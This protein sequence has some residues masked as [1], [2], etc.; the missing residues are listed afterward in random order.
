MQ[1]KFQPLNILQ[2]ASGFPGWGGTELHILN[3]SEQLTIRGHHVTVACRPGGWVSKKAMEMGLHTLD[4]TVIRQHDWSDYRK[5]KD[6][7]KSGKVDVVH[8]HW[9]TDAF[10]PAFAARVAG[11]PVRLMTRHSPYPF[12]TA[13]GRWLYTRVLYNR[14]LAI[15]GSV[16]Q[17]LINCG[18]P[19]DKIT[20]IHHGTNVGAFEN[21]TKDRESSRAEL[22]LT[23]DQVAVGI[24]GRIADEKGHRYLFD[25]LKKLPNAHNLRIVVVG[26]GP[27]ADEQREYVAANQL[28][29]RVIFSPFRADVNNVI[30]ALDIVTVPLTWEEPC[31]AVIQQAMALAKPV[32]GTKVGGTP[33]MI[34][35]GQTGVLVTPSDASS[36]ASAIETLL[37]D[38]ALR[39]KQGDAGAERVRALFTLDRMT[40]RIEELYRQELVRAG[41]AG[42]SAIAEAVTA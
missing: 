10:V 4:A 2:V 28:E 9:S 25:A 32:I 42:S 36:L 38:S 8:T 20:V 41:R 11:V 5:F 12:K 26:D 40:T 3:L 21:I 39:K 34:V 24:L 22:G 6:F 30:N 14:I 27:K 33:E 23:D 16:A 35:D 13:L 1:T 37:N 29:D 18:V 31:S 7:C 17:T 15:S 19:E